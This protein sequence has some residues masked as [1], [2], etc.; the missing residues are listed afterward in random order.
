MSSSKK[1]IKCKKSG[2]S[3]HIKD[4]YK[5]SRDDLV[6]RYCI[7]DATVKLDDIYDL[8][9]GDSID[10]LSYTKSVSLSSY[11]KYNKIIA[12]CDYLG[13]DVSS[14]N[15][16]TFQRLKKTMESSKFVFIADAVGGRGGVHDT[17]M[18]WSWIEQNVHKFKECGIDIL[19][20]EFV[21]NSYGENKYKLPSDV[22][23]EI[24]HKGLS[25]L[26]F[27]EKNHEKG[28]EILKK[29]ISNISVF[30]IETGRIRD[31]THYPIF[32]KDMVSSYKSEHKIAFFAGDS[33]QYYVCKDGE[34]LSPYF[35]DVFYSIS[36]RNFN[37][38]VVVSCI[39]N[40][41]PCNM[42]NYV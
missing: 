2:M 39:F 41:Y 1:T 6:W 18:L 10:S 24:L 35:P 31:Q 7:K 27:P 26:A 15:D 34:V 8:Y 16:I 19:C 21:K 22:G 36:N 42:V 3:D 29:I 37:R 25:N 11:D 33:Y 14:H 12:I 40:E 9:E 28:F 5:C 4:V 32:M 20:L 30:G 13:D 38:D 17:L 23:I